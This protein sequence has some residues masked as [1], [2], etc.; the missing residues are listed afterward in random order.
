MMRHRFSPVRRAVRRLFEHGRGQG[1]G[2]GEG[3][4]GA[5][6]VTE[7]GADTAA[8]AGAVKVKGTFSATESG[9][10]TAAFV[11]G[12]GFLTING[13][14][15]LLN[16]SAWT[17]YG[18]SD[19]HFELT[20]VGD[21]AAD[22]AKGATLLRTVVRK[23]GTYGTGYQQ[24]MQQEGQPGD[25]KPA[26]LAAIVARLTASKAAG[27]RNGVGMDSNKGQG[28]EASGGND[29]FGG[30]TEGNRQKG[31]FIGTAVYL[32]ENHG[33]LIDWFEQIVEPNSGVVPN[34]EALWA[35]QEEF[36]AAVLAVA[37]HMLFAT[38]PRDYASGNIANCINPAWLIPG[39]PFYGHVFMTCNFLDNLAMD[40]AQRVTR[41]ASVAS[42]RNT[43]GVPA[44]INQ[45]ATHFS[46]DPDNT[47]LDATMAL[48]DAA[49]GGAIGY[50]YWERVSMAGTADGLE[51]LSNI[52]DPD[53]TRLSHDA[54]IAVVTAHFSG[55]PYWM[56]APVISGDP[57][58]GELVAY[59]SGTAAGRPAP[60]LTARVRVDGVDKGDAAS[61]LIQAGDVGKAVV[62]RQ[63]AT[64]TAGAPTSDSAPVDA[65]DAGGGEEPTTWGEL[66]LMGVNINPQDDFNPSRM[67]RN[68][69][70][71]PRSFNSGT[72]GYENDVA[73]KTTGPNEGLG[74]PVAGSTFGYV[75]QTQL[76][77]AVDA[78]TYLLSVK[79]NNPFVQKGHGSLS[80]STYN[81]G[82]NRTT[83]TLTMGPGLSS[84]DIIA[85]GHNSVTS[86]FGD[87]KVMQPGYAVNDT[88]L[89]TTLAQAHY[90]RFEDGVARGMDA[91]DTNNQNLEEN[92]AGS[93]VA[94]RTQGALYSH[95]FEKVFDIADAIGAKPW[96]NYPARFSDAFA[97]SAMTYAIEQLTAGR[98]FTRIIKEFSNEPWNYAF[99][100]YWDIMDQVLE[101]ANLACGSTDGSLRSDRRILS[102][103][104]VGTTVTVKLNFLHG[105]SV[106]QTIYDASDYNSG[107]GV[108]TI[109]PGVRTLT[110]T[111][112]GA[113]AG[114]NLVFEHPTSGNFTGSVRTGWF[115]SYVYLDATN[116]LCVPSTVLTT[117]DERYPG[118]TGVK[119][120]WE[121]RRQYAM[122]TAAVTAGVRANISLVKGV[123]LD[124]DQCWFENRHGLAFALEKGWGLDWLFQNNGGFCPAYY[125]RP[126]DGVPAGFTNAD[127]VF[128]ELEN[129]REFVKPW[130]LKWTNMMATLGQRSTWCYEGGIHTHDTPNPTSKTAVRDA[131]LDARMSTLLLNAHQDYANRAAGGGIAYYQGGAGRSFGDG[132]GTW[133]LIEA[134]MANTSQPKNAAMTALAATVYAPTEEAGVNAGTLRV[135]DVMFPFGGWSQP[136]NGMFAFGSDAG[137]PPDG[138][139]V[140]RWFPAAGDYDVSI[141]AGSTDTSDQIRLL[142]DSVQQG[143]AANL[144]SYAGDSTVP[145]TA[146]TRT[147]TLT[148]GWHRMQA[149]FDADRLGYSGMASFVT[150]AH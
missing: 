36:M 95:S 47:N 111:G 113:E 112:A 63:T 110:A 23:Y 57:T 125:L 20:H 29:F 81:A 119:T 8:F 127:D 104:R 146:L 34:K 41:A 149:K 135:A 73:L 108:R 14:G 40:A 145:A 136:G 76:T 132:N 116:E 44:W 97:L 10:D 30:L 39:N 75:L 56:T 80:A 6:A 141:K 137:L 105:R 67:F 28:V 131:H 52:A 139:C 55:V 11:G 122:H 31:L 90:G 70:L 72:Y 69:A 114:K 21:E 62:I 82:T 5:L 93:V 89:L 143:A 46:N 123:Q 42:T 1:G 58:V 115:D 27:M 77:D 2:G 150:A 66:G 129:R 87:L 3:V 43:Q 86:D 126:R 17:P 74:Y 101:D 102:V 144:P 68:L 4:T 19:G 54:R 71:A 130:I 120:R 13:T 45:L 117:L 118:P 32:A 49:T 12:G 107:T 138:F 7:T 60:T 18:L 96:V 84:G 83:A 22:A 78:G 140:M 85:L 65:V 38:G 48:H 99:P 100:G 103:A 33:D 147:V 91:T 79:G 94:G 92:W 24:D 61:Y 15:F 121:T 109:T 35:Y 128:A 26:Y 133:P 134:S 37:P 50:N 59:T 88:V 142:V 106:G 16:G 51:Y 98:T 53:S 25:L 64:N 9:S 148:K 124:G